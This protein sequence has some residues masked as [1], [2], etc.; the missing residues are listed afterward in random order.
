MVGCSVAYPSFLVCRDHPPERVPQ[1]VRDSTPV[2]IK[3]L[4][5]R[6]AS[7]HVQLCQIEPAKYQTPR[8]RMKAFSQ[9]SGSGIA[10]HSCARIVNSAGNPSGSSRAAIVHTRPTGTQ[11]KEMKR[12]I[13]F[14]CF[15]LLGFMAGY[16]REQAALGA[17]LG[18]LGMCTR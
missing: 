12:P 4:C 16:G 17:T 6:T 15:A 5:L 7:K 11:A 9:V 10:A 18:F 1:F 3:R 13:V 14:E 8:R 2:Q